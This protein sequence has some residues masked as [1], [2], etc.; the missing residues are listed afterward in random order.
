M[1]TP[2]QRV[3]SGATFLGGLSFVA[4][5]GYTYLSGKSW[6]DSVYWF[7]ITVSSVGYTEESQITPSLQIFSIGVIAAG[8]LAAAYTIGGLIQMLTE[9]EIER[10]M[11]A[12][13]MTRELKHIDGHVIICGFGRIGQILAEDLTSHSVP[14]VVIDVNTKQVADGNSLG[15]LTLTGDATDEDVLQAAGVER[16]KTLVS[17]LDSDADNV[18]LTLTARTLNR[19]VRII[20]RGEQESTKR[21]LIQAGANR[22][23]L[24]AVI[25][26]R[27]IASMV[28][29]PH[30]AEVIDQMTDR[31]M[32][33]VDLEEVTL[34]ETSPL[35]G[36]TVRSAD[37]RHR[38]QVL[39]VAV[40]RPT[41]EM[42]FNPD[43][44]QELAA[45][46]TLI[47]MGRG[48]AITEFRRVCEGP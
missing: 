14:F 8:M 18:F 2:L 33:D 45:D 34:A 31:K 12:R 11:G 6:L 25:G 16:A 15:Y 41:G 36:K 22:V 43:A 28:T 19:D 4:V 35:A 21:K 37:P 42:I 26:A 29:R 46:D 44:G 7:V 10:A 47:V 38:H 5:C 27:R 40:R 3:R 30:A 20:A 17:A 9:G 23:V 24:P 32:L 48:E 1:K 39:V 13:R